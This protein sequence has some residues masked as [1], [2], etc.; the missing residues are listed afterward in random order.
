M[1]GK[2]ISLFGSIA[3]KAI[4]S[5][6]ETVINISSQLNAPEIQKSLESSEKGIKNINNFL[7]G[8]HELINNI[9]STLKPSELIKLSILTKILD[10]VKF[11]SINKAL[12]IIASSINSINIDG[13]TINAKKKSLNS[14]LEAIKTLQDIIKA[15]T[16]LSLA[17]IPASA[18]IIPGMAVVKLLTKTIMWS[19][20]SIGDMSKGA[21]KKDRKSVV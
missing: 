20:Q 5:V 13:R 2:S 12:D 16:L 18:I 17:A 4:K 11:N 10:K 9:L 7:K 21:K 15:A 8:I 19:L 14:I 1:A 3:E 6:S